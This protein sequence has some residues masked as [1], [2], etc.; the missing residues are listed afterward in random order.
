MN[1]PINSLTWLA[2][3]LNSRNLMLKAGQIILTGAVIQSRGIKSGDKVTFSLTNLPF[4]DEI[5]FQFDIQE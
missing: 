2:N 1:N 5:I 3:E 4:N